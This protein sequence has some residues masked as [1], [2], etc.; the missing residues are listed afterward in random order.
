M[1]I[2]SHMGQNYSMSTSVSKPSIAPLGSVAPDFEMPAL[3]GP[4]V[5][6]SDFANAPAF[7]VAFLSNSC[8]HSR[9]IEPGNAPG[10]N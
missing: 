10:G 2:T 5:K 3:D 8:P 4:I 1:A 7:L 9:H 6:L